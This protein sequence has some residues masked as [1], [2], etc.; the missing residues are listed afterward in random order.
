MPTLTSATVANYAVLNPLDITNT[1]KP[2]NG[3]LTYSPSSTSPQVSI[4]TI[5]IPSSGNWYAEFTKSSSTSNWSA[6]IIGPGRTDTYTG[7]TNSIGYF[8][9]G[10]IYKDGTLIQSSL[11]TLASGDVLGVAVNSVSQTV[12]FYKN[13]STVGTAISY[14]YSQVWF[15]C[16]CLLYTS[17]AAD[18]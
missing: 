18:E 11:S 1:T 2:T 13:G 9:T 15:A 4:S 12:Q 14:T 16:G 7:S 17:D 3:N 6:G 10:Q 5:G 8:D